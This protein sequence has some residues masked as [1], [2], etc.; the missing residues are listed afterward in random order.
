M[1]W[2]NFAKF[3]C[4]TKSTIIERNAN[5]SKCHGLIKI[6]INYRTGTLQRTRNSSTVE[7]QHRAQLLNLCA[8]SVDIFRS[9]HNDTGRPASSPKS[10][11]CTLG[12][13]PNLARPNLWRFKSAFDW[14]GL[15]YWLVPGIAEFVLNWFQS[16]IKASN[17]KLD[18]QQQRRKA[19]MRER[20]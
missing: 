11:H 12:Q 6:C 14:V 5:R 1:P 20:W 15:D 17:N 4:Q 2:T 9:N 7:G 19:A 18:I 3:P 13:E 16:T 10:V 8:I